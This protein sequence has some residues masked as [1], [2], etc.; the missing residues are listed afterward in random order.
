M[1]IPGFY[2]FP[3]L[4]S[5]FFGLV[6]AILIMVLDDQIDT[7]TII[8]GI[9]VGLLVCVWIYYH[10]SKRKDLLKRISR[11]PLKLK[12]IQFLQDNILFFRNLSEENKKRFEKDIQIFLFKTKITPI[13]CS[14]ERTDKLLVASS[15][16]IP[17]FG[18]DTWNYPMLKEVLLYPHR[19]DQNYQTEGMDRDILG[20]VGQGVLN[21]KMILSLPALR[22]S[23]QNVGS[24]SNVG[25]HEF[26]HL[27]DGADG[28]TDGLPQIV[29]DKQYIIPWLNLIHKEIERIKKGNSDINPYGATNQQEFFA[30]ASEYFFSR[31]DL[32]KTRHPEL[33]SMLS[34]IFRQDVES[35]IGPNLRHLP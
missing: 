11:K 10:L 30:V 24:C 19:F 17:I 32:L 20:M 16:V 31:P 21:G 15:A 13:D 6:V 14:I 29:M 28:T 3:A 35:L 23:F 5:V 12:D 4:V 34:Q 25:I 22:A 26:T 7:F 9:V 33:Y 8:F 18:F 27:I 1:R 2:F